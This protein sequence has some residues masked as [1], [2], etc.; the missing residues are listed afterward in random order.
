MEKYIIAPPAGSQTN[1]IGAKDRPWEEVHAKRYPGLNEYLAESTG[2]GIVSGCEPSISGLTVTVGAGVVHLADGT[3]KEIAQTNITLDNA[4]PTNPRID[5]VYIDSTG[6]VAKITGMAAASPS[7]S[8]MPT[9]GISV[10]NVTIAASATTGALTDKRGML[11]RFYNTGIVNVKDFGAKGDG[12]HDDTVSIQSAIDNNKGKIIRFPYGTYII[13]SPIITYRGDSKR[14][15]LILENATLKAS[16]DF[17]NTANTFMVSLGDSS[18]GSYDSYWDSQTMCGLIGGEIDGNHVAY[19]GIEYNDSSLGKIMDCSVENVSDCGI[20]IGADGATNSTDIYISRVKIDGEAKENSIGL[21]VNSYDN[22]IEYVRTSRFPIGIKITGGGNFFRECHPLYNQTQYSNEVGFLIEGEDNRLSQCY[23][24]MFETGIKISTTGRVCIDDFFY[25]RH[26]SKQ[27][28][29]VFVKNT[30]GSVGF[31]VNGFYCSFV[32]SD[33]SSK[34]Y[35][36]PEAVTPFSSLTQCENTGYYG[37]YNGIYKNYTPVQADKGCFS[38]LAHQIIGTIPKQFDWNKLTCEGMYSLDN[39]NT[40][41]NTTY[42][43]PSSLGGWAT[44]EVKVVPLI[45]YR[46]YLTVRQTAYSVAS[47]YTDVMFTRVY[48]GEFDSNGQVIDGSWG[49]WKK[50]TMS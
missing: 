43:R 16:G 23:S 2:Y 17:P 37:F 40:S 35:D 34:I 46:R 27:K 12:A 45:R 24:D 11:P 29:A 38:S 44:V 5:L 1:A 18:T 36:G 30:A 9:G 6:T 42:H 31:Y 13:S 39:A 26:A 50:I 4:D 15:L 25:Y 7:V 32:S 47:G 10:C 3:R 19:G 28:N 41:E 22:N 49:P 21:L 8:A 48:F 33:L 20:K 14:S